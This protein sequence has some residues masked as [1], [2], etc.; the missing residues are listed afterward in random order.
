MPTEEAFTAAEIAAYCTARLPDLKQTISGEWRGPC[1]IHQGGRDSF[2]VDPETG[3]WFCHSK[4]GR[5]G[6]LISLEMELGETDFKS[7]K[8]EV[9]R[10]S[11]RV[12]YAA[13][14]TLKK[15]FP[16]VADYS[17]TFLDQRIHEFAEEH[18]V[19]YVASYAYRYPDRRFAYVKVKFKAADGKKTF[20]KYAPTEKGGWTSPSTAGVPALLYNAHL[21][22]CAESAD[23]FSDQLRAA[24][25]QF[26]GAPF[27][28]F[29]RRLSGRSEQI[30]EKIR[31]LRSQFMERCVPEGATGEVKRAAGRFALIGIAGELATRWNLTGWD[32]G[33]ALRAA[34]RLFNE[35]RKRRGTTGSFDELAMIQQVRRILETATVDSKNSRRM[36]I[37][38]TRCANALA[39]ADP[40]RAPR[41]PNISC[42]RR[43]SK[44]NCVQDLTSVRCARHCTGMITWSERIRT[45]LSSPVN[46]QG[47]QQRC[48]C[49]ASEPQSSDK[50]KREFQRVQ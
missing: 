8:A 28:E 45:G 12:H 6:G 43:P 15:A 36:A 4:C 30:V 18:H 47:S 38:I 19:K 14:K 48:E 11:G 26:Y 46:C 40:I 16:Q 33:E 44:R 20:Q 7:A 5:G 1:P 21:L 31:Q 49:T 25:R 37:R 17:W 23:V 35:W 22:H 50:Q 24:A 41:R 2:A 34:E 27:R 13:S 29:V 42:S 10:I 9:L 32:K 39:F 3:R